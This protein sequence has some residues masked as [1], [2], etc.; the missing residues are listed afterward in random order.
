[1][2]QVCA[3]LRSPF[4]VPSNLRSVRRQRP[5]S[6]P[7]PHSAAICL[8]VDAPPAMASATTWLVIPLHKQ[9]N[10]GRPA[11]SSIRIMS[12]NLPTNTGG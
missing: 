10:T 12:K 4:G 6:A 9:T 3:L 5:H 7:A 1:M 2:I 8:V 11:Y